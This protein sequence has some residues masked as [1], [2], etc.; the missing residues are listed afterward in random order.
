MFIDLVQI[1]LYLR[2]YTNLNSLLKGAKLQA[3]NSMLN[4]LNPALKFEFAGYSISS[5]NG[6]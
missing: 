1:F 6:C 5:G 3:C 4:N 2:K